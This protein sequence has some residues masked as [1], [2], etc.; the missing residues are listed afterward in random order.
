LEIAGKKGK[1]I[2][3][4]CMAR[5]LGKRRG[6]ADKGEGSWK[7]V[8]RRLEGGRRKKGGEVPYLGWGGGVFDFGLGA[9]VPRNIHERGR[10]RG[11][12]SKK[13][14]MIPSRSARDNNQERGK[15]GSF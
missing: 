2:S 3:E 15:K 4:R 14:C 11:G 10:A 12:K 8:E 13:V 6:T 7:R 1:V 5:N 9:D